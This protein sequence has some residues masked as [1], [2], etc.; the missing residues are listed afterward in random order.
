MPIACRAFSPCSHLHD[1][2]RAATQLR[3]DISVHAK[4]SAQCKARNGKD[5]GV[6][7]DP[8]PT[9]CQHVDRGTNEPYQA[10]GTAHEKSAACSGIA[11]FRKRGSREQ[12]RQPEEQV[13][14]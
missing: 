6:T 9:P 8:D 2:R 3:R 7:K 12:E 1:R 10:E 13:P 11:S 14:G 4:R 5:D